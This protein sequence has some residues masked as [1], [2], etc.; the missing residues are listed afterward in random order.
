MK[1]PKWSVLAFN[2]RVWQWVLC[3]LLCLALL[4]VACF[5]CLCFF[6]SL[7]ALVC[8]VG[9]PCYF[10]CCLWVFVFHSFVIPFSI[11]TLVCLH[12]S[13]TAYPFL[14]LSLYSFIYL[15]LYLRIY[16]SLVSM[17][18]VPSNFEHYFAQFFA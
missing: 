8:V 7:F 14:Y 2:L 5:L 17:C 3:R 12:F 11:C 9:W 6:V 13:L 1:N 16:T 10:Y 4:C 15:T 18:K